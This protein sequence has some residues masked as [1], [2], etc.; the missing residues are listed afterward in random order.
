MDMH[1]W[2]PNLNQI[3]QMLDVIGINDVDELFYDIPQDIL[4]ES[5]VEV[6]YN[7]PLS[8]EEIRQRL[9]QVKQKNRKLKY[10]PFLGGGLVNIA[11]LQLSSLSFLGRSF[12][13]PT[14]L[15]NP[16]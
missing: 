15:I 9:E 8:E 6:G 1:P 16:R 2:L 5:P 13:P 3:R 11:F 7:K 14:L 12:T 10:P 4:L